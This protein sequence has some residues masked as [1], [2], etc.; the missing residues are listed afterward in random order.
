MA[1]MPLADAMF[2]VPESRE[3][4]M[5]VGSLQLFTPPE[6]S[7]PEYLTE[8]YLDALKA[9]DIAKAFRRRP[10][11]SLATLGQWTWV[12][13]PEIDLEHHIR[14]S[15][16]P[17]P[18]RVR[19]LLALVSRLHGTLLDRHRPLWEAHLIEGLV[20]GRFAVY[21]KLHHALMDGVSG[22]RLLERT[23]STDADSREVRMP[24]EERPRT[25]RTK[26]K[27]AGG[28][29]LSLPMQAGQAVWDLAALTPRVLE[30]AGQGLREQAVALPMQAPR[31]VLNVPITG[32]RRFAAQAWS[33]DRIR[34]VGRA[35]DATINDVVLAMC[36]SALR[37]YLRELDALPDAPL[38]AMTPVSLRDE[39]DDD[40]GNAVGTILCNLGT[41]LADPEERL[42]AIKASM[43]AAKEGLRGL[44]QL[45]VTA[46]SAAVMS[47]MVLAQL[48]GIASAVR[49]P[50]NLVISNVPGPKEPLYWNGARLEGMYPLSIP[51]AGQALN[52]TVTS[53]AGQMEFGLIGCRRS[54]PHLQRL[55][56]ALDEGLAEL[57]KAFAT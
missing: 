55:L 20:D 34:A 36:A 24:F 12:D 2:L 47:P 40:G 32:S 11:R 26:K 5:H 57:E 54:L 15:A 46:L 50:F 52:I 37:R 8:L 6:G 56:P 10:H 38:V 48:P 23:L 42:V 22:L 33:M 45:Q 13:D 27:G 7:G 28:G 18:G 9:T 4:P 1:L 30:L 49:P 43:Q 21:T 39:D 41:D 19:E 44:N 29:L 35:A 31:S 51:T 17:P 3:Q 25:A 53:Y 14:H 16:L